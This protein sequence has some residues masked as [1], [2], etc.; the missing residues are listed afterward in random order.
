MQISIRAILLLV[1]I[2]A[3]LSS[4]TGI[5]QS[6]YRMATETLACGLP[7]YLQFAYSQLQRFQLIVKVVQQNVGQQWR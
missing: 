3:V 4:L 7:G 5:L 6:L 2:A 1:T